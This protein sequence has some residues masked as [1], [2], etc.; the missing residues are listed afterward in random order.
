M[1]GNDGP[2][3]SKPPAPMETESA[4]LIQVPEAERVVSRHRGRLDPAAA[5]GVPA[6]VTVLYPFVAPSAITAATLAVLAE[7]VASVSAFDCQF[8]VTAWFGQEVMWL[9]PR[10][11]QPF[12]DLT[13]TVA[14]A[15]P[16]FPPYGGAHDDVVPHLT[17]GD[18][19]G[20]AADLRAAE[21]ELLP[22]LPICVH[23]SQVWL[24]IGATAPDS[25]RAV[26]ELPLRQIRS[27]RLMRATLG[28][29]WLDELHDHV[30]SASSIAVF[31][32]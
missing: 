9:A 24:M 14:A 32:S 10:P 4:V 2:V 25:W 13:H 6:H 1:L 26:A 16:G 28:A 22:A 18:R 19:P 5:L 11:E 3:E 31:F 15:F 8:P 20:G 17:V 21:A 7:A 29:P 12:R 23:V 27:P 30:N